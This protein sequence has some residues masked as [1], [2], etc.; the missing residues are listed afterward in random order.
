MYHIGF[1]GTL[2]CTIRASFI[3]TLAIIMATLAL[4]SGDCFAQPATRRVPPAPLG[5]PNVPL[6]P[7][8]N[9]YGTPP[10]AVG[11]APFV[12]PV[13]PSAG[14]PVF[15]P[16]PA[17]Y[18]LVPNA[19]R[20]PTPFEPGLAVGPQDRSLVPIPIPAPSS[21]QPA[22]EMPGP[23]GNLRLTVKENFLNRL[24]ARNETKP[25][26]VRD[27]ILGAQVFGHQTT[28]TKVRLDLLPAATNGRAALVLNG[29]T[30]SETTGVT[31]QAKVDVASQQ[32]FVAFKEIYFDGDKFTTR[33]AVVHVR[34]KNQTLGAVT[35]L[36]GTLFGGIA[37]RIAF[38]EAERRRPAAEAVARDRV[39]ERV[40]PEFD[41]AIDQQLATANDELEQSVRRLLRTADL[42]PSAQQVTT[43]DT[44][45][46][47][48]MQ[49]A[50][51]A[52]T[53]STEGLE[54]RLGSENGLKLMVHESLLN[55]LIAKFGLKGMR[56]TD[57]EIE[58]SMTP[59]IYKPADDELEAAEPP[60][61][62]IPGMENL[63]IDIEFDE[64]DPLTIRLEEDRAVVTLRAKF[65]P[66]GKDVLPALAVTIPYTSK[67]IGEKI[68]VSP[69]KVAV[70]PL[71]KDGDTPLPPVAL[72]LI[73]TAIE[74][75]LTKFAVDRVLPASLWQMPGPVPRVI[76]I[77]THDGWGGVSID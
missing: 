42:L 60:A 22:V 3:R 36:T 31:P 14:P 66:A 59:F 65:K 37:N 71:V 13:I 11:P 73:S 70:E 64:Y 2:F 9:P 39:A 33:H 55:S 24:V 12:T 6:G 20:R 16:A 44:Q 61:M 43:T 52:S 17:I 58:K 1:T 51:E 30:Q 76:S 29:T 62:S 19:T 34:A 15:Y 47:Y 48:S 54:D 7:V 8:A 49:V 40:Y 56:T 77:H 68:V 75:S 23:I 25:G 57:R 10:V 5:S 67:V 45:L 35:P 41:K 50:E 72:K 32:E 4:V 27:F 38:R 46:N 53:P 28:A 26:E 74:S 21:L 63:I 18:P 69:G